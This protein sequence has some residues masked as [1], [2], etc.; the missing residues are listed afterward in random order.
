MD[1][2]T[3]LLIVTG[4]FFYRVRCRA[5]LIERLGDEVLREGALRVDVLRLE[6]LP[7]EDTREGELLGV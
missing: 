7:D 4:R 3:R 6:E 5:W 1:F 2:S